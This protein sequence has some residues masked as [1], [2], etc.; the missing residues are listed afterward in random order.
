MNDS[1]L[2]HT[3]QVKT[4]LAVSPTQGPLERSKRGLVENQIETDRTSRDCTRTRQSKNE[5]RV[6]DHVRA[7]LG[8][9][10]DVSAVSVRTR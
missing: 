6:K 8:L 10:Q 7:S 5:K 4:G 2:Y 3:E 1:I 9:G